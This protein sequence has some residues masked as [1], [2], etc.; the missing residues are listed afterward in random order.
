MCNE[1]NHSEPLWEYA[2]RE[3]D[4][5]VLVKDNSFNLRLR[6]NN[7]LRY[8]VT[9][10]GVH[11]E[12]DYDKTLKELASNLQGIIALITGGAFPYG[13]FTPEGL[14][15][16]D[17]QL[18]IDEK[19][20]VVTPGSIKLTEAPR[21]VSLITK[22][23]LGINDYEIRRAMMLIPLL[24]WDSESL[25]EMI[26]AVAN[27]V[28]EVE[29][30]AATDVVPQATK[31]I[32]DLVEVDLSTAGAST[33][34]GTLSSLIDSL[35]SQNEKMSEKVK[36]LGER[37][38]KS[39]IESIK[40]GNRHIYQKQWID[41]RFTFSDPFEGQ[42]EGSIT[43]E[44]S[45]VIELLELAM[46]EF[47]ERMDHLVRSRQVLVENLKTLH[48]ILADAR[49]ALTKTKLGTEL[50]YRN[51]IPKGK[52]EKVT[53]AVK[54]RNFKVENNLNV[55]IEEKDLLSTQVKLGRTHLFYPQVF[56]GI[57]YGEMNYTNLLAEQDSLGVVRVKDNDRLES[58]LH[59][60]GMVN[61]NIKTGRKSEV[62]FLQVGASVKKQRPLL[63]TGAGVRLA[64]WI[65]I[66]GGVMFT[67]IPELK[68]LKVGDPIK[69]QEALEKDFRYQF[70]DVRGYVSLQLRPSSLT[71]QPD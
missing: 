42:G 7:P 20:R 39:E 6:L 40:E 49:E 71:K 43:S 69:D 56:P 10:Q 51:V 67:W 60:A 48:T 33:A 61:F 66:S 18:K 11:E 68:S 8:A 54:E 31:L 3:A 16:M 53:I 23:A 46:E 52:V 13:S 22:T 45:E 21:N 26:Q 30:D 47:V 63:F 1:S 32:K 36:A 19:P 15:L 41:P 70:S 28:K 35:R 38:K 58:Y 5:L 55:V 24:E 12:D 37:L 9:V 57:A 2:I 65:G 62:P 27:R 50:L 44:T 4:P 64:E 25:S 17:V 59:V 14:K 34:L 29:K